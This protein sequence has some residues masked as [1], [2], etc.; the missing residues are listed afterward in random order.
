MAYARFQ[1]VHFA[2][3]ALVLLIGRELLRIGRPA[4]DRTIAVSPAR[5]VGRVSEIPRAVFGE[6]LFLAGCEVANPQIVI[7]NECGALLVG[8]WRIGARTRA[9]VS[10]GHK[11]AGHSR[12]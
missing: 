7:A 12:A 11:Y 9:G 2:D 1:Q 10:L 8:R 6:L 3:A 5:V 4:H